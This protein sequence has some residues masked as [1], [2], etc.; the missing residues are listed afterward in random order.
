MLQYLHQLFEY[1]AYVLAP[2]IDHRIDVTLALAVAIILV[3]V[4]AA[5]VALPR[6]VHIGFAVAQIC[7]ATPRTR[8]RTAPLFGRRVRPTARPRAPAMA[9]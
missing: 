9:V 7:G 4:F 6:R 5:L 1:T 2:V 8:S 3:V